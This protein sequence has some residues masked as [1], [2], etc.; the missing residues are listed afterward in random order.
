VGKSALLA[1]WVQRRKTHMHRDDF[2][3]Q[4]FVGSSP[5]SHRLADVLARLETALKEH[6]HLREMEVPETEDRLR[7]GLVRY[8]EA[9][10]KKAV[11]SQ[12]MLIVIDGINVLASEASSHGSLHWLPTE[13]PANVRFILSTSLSGAIGAGESIRSSTSINST[14]A[15]T[16]TAY[17]MDDSGVDEDA[18]ERDEK[19]TCHFATPQ[20]AQTAAHDAERTYME[21]CRRKCHFLRMAPLTPAV[22]EQII[23]EFLRQQDSERERQQGLE[24]RALVLEEH[25]QS[26]IISAEET[27][28]PLFLRMLLYALHVGATLPNH[29]CPPVDEQL[30][31]Y[32]GAGACPTR[33]VAQ[34]LDAAKASIEMSEDGSH[35]TKGLLGH[36]LAAVHA[37]RN[38]LSDEELYGLVDLAMGTKGV[39]SSS[40]EAIF[41]LLKG[42]TLVVN[43][44]R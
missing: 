11:G 43:G 14:Y 20:I 41:A 34:L 8:L 18:E 21:L 24:P 7:W 12:V 33:I 38:G 4:H 25:Q 27:N 17:H 31:A 3:F 30:N 22:R 26:R 42:T 15:P 37:S 29:H 9:A 19:S 1:N 16:S 28:C 6:F 39:A 23:T 40:M 44:L 35:R 32:L 5:R 10:S 36:V 2:L 13:L